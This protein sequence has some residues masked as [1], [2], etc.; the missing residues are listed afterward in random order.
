VAR[1][2]RKTAAELRQLHFRERDEAV[3][4]ML[5]GYAQLVKDGSPINPIRY[6]PAIADDLFCCL[7][8]LASSI[9]A[10]LVD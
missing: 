2:K 8:G 4:K 5:E 3:A 6:P 10:G 7:R 9:R 1:K